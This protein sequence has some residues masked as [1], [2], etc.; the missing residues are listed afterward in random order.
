M[1]LKKKKKHKISEGPV[2]HNYHPC[3]CFF[4]TLGEFFIKAGGLVSQ[5]LAI[6]QQG[7]KEEAQ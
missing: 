6:N 1:I 4:F 5:V 7:K 3:C 2:L